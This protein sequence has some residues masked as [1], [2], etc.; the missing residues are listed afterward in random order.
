VG[1]QIRQ[2]GWPAPAIE[3][4]KADARRAGELDGRAFASE[5]LLARADTAL[6]S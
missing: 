4:L 3:M 6:P 1:H 2:L 5:A